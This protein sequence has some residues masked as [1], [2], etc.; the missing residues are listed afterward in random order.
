M[1]GTEGGT[2]P[3]FKGTLQRIYQDLLSETEYII[4]IIDA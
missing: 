1:K 4:C 2:Q 3:L